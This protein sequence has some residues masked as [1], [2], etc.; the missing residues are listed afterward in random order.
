MTEQEN[1]LLRIEN[2]NI[3]EKKYL[4]TIATFVEHEFNGQN[5]GTTLYKSSEEDAYNHGFQNLVTI[6]TGPVSQ[7]IRRKLEFVTIALIEYKT[8]EFNNKFPFKNIEEVP[9]INLMAKKLK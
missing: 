1:N 5:I 2:N 6:S 3:A 8:F 7:H 4:Y 9:T